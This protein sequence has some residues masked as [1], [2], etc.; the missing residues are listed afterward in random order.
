M[1]T[2]PVVLTAVLLLKVAVLFFDQFQ[3]HIHIQDIS[4]AQATL[5]YSSIF[6]S[7]RAVK[8]NPNATSF[9]S[10]FAVLYF[11]YLVIMISCRNVLFPIVGNGIVD[12]YHVIRHVMNLETVNTYEGELVYSNIFTH[13]LY[14]TG[15]HDIHAL[16]LGRAITGIQAFSHK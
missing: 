1:Y 7:S 3:L 13:V 16:I 8:F 6:L 11:K 15:T 12:E 9:H 10:L 14:S 4:A 2:A 5:I